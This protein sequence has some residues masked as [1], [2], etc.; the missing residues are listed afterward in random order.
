MKSRFFLLL[1]TSIF[2]NISMNTAEAKSATAKQVVVRFQSAVL[3]VMKQGKKLGF[4]GR[5]KRLEKAIKDSHNLT[6]ITRVVIGREWGKLS[7]PQQQ[8]LIEVFT[9]LSIATYAFNFKDFSGEAFSF[10]SKEK[11]TRGGMII[12]THL[13][14]PKDKDVTFDYMLKEKEGRWAI[15][16]VIANG[17]SDLALKRSEYTKVLKEKGFDILLLTLNEKIKTYEK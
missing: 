15:I 3:K 8:Q 9:K 11:T 2:L 14:I 6:K 5:Y 1:V 17:V 7:E 13:S 12:H 10:D 4:E 16:N